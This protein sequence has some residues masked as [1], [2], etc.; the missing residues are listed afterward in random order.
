MEMLSWARHFH[1]YPITWKRCWLSLQ[2]KLVSRA[3]S[4]L[5][6]V[7]RFDG[8]ISLDWKLWGLVYMRTTLC[9][10]VRTG[11]NA[12]EHSELVQDVLANGGVSDVRGEVKRKGVTVWQGRSILTSDTFS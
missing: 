11:L 8:S 2:A 5:A 10:T 9:N 7:E 1:L 4:W 12:P 3:T 6:C